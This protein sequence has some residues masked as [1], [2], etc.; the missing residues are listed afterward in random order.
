M[1]KKW[2]NIR[3]FL[4]LLYKLK[5]SIMIILMPF[6]FI[7]PILDIL[8]VKAA[9]ELINKL[10]TSSTTSEKITYMLVLLS[11]VFITSLCRIC[12]E[13]LNVKAKLKMNLK[14]KIMLIEQVVKV[15]FLTYENK[16]FRRKLTL[17]Q[18]QLSSTISNLIVILGSVFMSITKIVV[19]LFSIYAISNTFMLLLVTIIIVPISLLRGFINRTTLQITW[20]NTSDV[21]QSRYYGSMITNHMH[22]AELS[23]HKLYPEFIKRWKKFTGNYTRKNKEDEINKLNKTFIINLLMGITIGLFVFSLIINIRTN[24]WRSGD[25]FF[26]ISA[27]MNL[28]ATSEIFISQMFQLSLQSDQYSVYKEVF[29]L[30]QEQLKS[31]Q[32]TNEGDLNEKFIV[33]KNVTLIYENSKEPVLNNVSF[34]INKGER[35]AFV[36]ENGAGKTSIYFCMLGL[37]KPTQG[38]VYVNGKEPYYMSP[39]ERKQ[40][41]SVVFQDFAVYH[42]LSLY[43][44]VFF[45][46]T[47]M[48]GTDLLGFKGLDR[49]LGKNIGGV[50]L[51]GGE[52]QKLA[53]IRAIYG[54]GQTLVMDEPTSALDPIAE[55]NILSEI[56]HSLK[57]RTFILTTHRMGITLSL[58]KIFVISKGDV[59]ESGSPK[60]LLKINNGKYKNMV[61]KQGEIFKKCT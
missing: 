2:S 47:K 32:T 38:H 15:P 28:I 6:V 57:G 43:D 17:A 8:N 39:T 25:I 10:T 3:E 18:S 30:E 33:F 53:V 61:M 42:G 5:D 44:N 12:W 45:G 23:I 36:G 19:L 22:G 52:L 59:V 54:N 16:Q 31:T 21:I 13:T 20:Q 35:V 1:K 27:Y 60:E 24:E 58:D 55:E 51:S 4:I 50:E 9:S 11:I 14:C 7:I 48:I 37:V 34:E 26:L 41:F 29:H 56:I 49:L 40:L 46:K